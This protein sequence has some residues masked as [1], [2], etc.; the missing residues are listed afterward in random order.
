MKKL[1]SRRDWHQK[2]TLTDGLVHLTSLLNGWIDTLISNLIQKSNSVKLTKKSA[3]ADFGDPTKVGSDL[4]YHLVRNISQK[5]LNVK[6]KKKSVEVAGFAPAEPWV[7]IQVPYLSTPTPLSTLSLSFWLVQ[8]LLGIAALLRSLAMTR[9]QWQ[10][11]FLRVTKKTLVSI[12]ILVILLPSFSFYF[13]L[14]PSS[15]SASW[16]DDN[17]AYYGNFDRVEFI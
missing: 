2:T 4:D 13:L 5:E 6:P 9:R 8:N 3:F 14:H 11:G 7:I 10:L 1:L 17:G 16:F 15:V 12:L